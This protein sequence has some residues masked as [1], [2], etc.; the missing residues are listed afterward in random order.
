MT[1]VLA[2]KDAAVAV[3]QSPASGHEGPASDALHELFHR[4]RVAASL[5]PPATGLRRETAEAIGPRRLFGQTTADRGENTPHDEQHDD[6][7]QDIRCIND[8][9]QSTGRR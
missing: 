5:L 7:Q 1:A 6:N 2:A 3:R 9:S 8:P 4:A